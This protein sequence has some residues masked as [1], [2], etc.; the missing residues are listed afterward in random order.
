MCEKIA[1]F[2]RAFSSSSEEGKLFYF[3]FIATPLGEM[4]AVVDEEKLHVLEFCDLATL[5]E[6]LKKLQKYKPVKMI[7]GSNLIFERVGEELSAYFSGQTAKFSV[8][9]VLNGSDFECQSWK[10]LMQIPA[11]TT[12]SY[13]QQAKIMERPT[14]YRAVAR[15]NSQNKIAIIIPCHRVVGIDGQLTGYAGGIERKKW[16]LAHEKQYFSQGL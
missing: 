14:A 7:L 1:S 15:A 2:L 13:A 11:A 16:L 10:I 4:I 9:C 3:G 8:E 12:Y 5:E 6:R